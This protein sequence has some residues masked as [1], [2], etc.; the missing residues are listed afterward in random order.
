M[1][2]TRWASML[3]GL[4]AVALG[5]H[6]VASPAFAQNS[7]LR[8]GLFGRAPE[9]KA[10]MPAVSRFVSE[11]GESFVLDRSGQKALLRFEG[12]PEVWVLTPQYAPR[13]DILYKNDQGAT[14][15]RATRVGGVIVFTADRPGGAAAAP[16]GATAPLRLNAIG[17]QQLL[18]VLA[19]ASTRASHAAQRLIPFEAD[20]TPDTS[21]L[22]ADAAMVTS[23]AVMR[24]SRRGDGK[25]L[26]G[27]VTRVSIGAGDKPQVILDGG[28]LKVIVAPSMGLS[29]RPS[30]D[31]IAFVLGAR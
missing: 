25:K 28:A 31:R 11:T 1:V 18:R 29:G 13:G 3:A 22:V 20:A 4:M 15:L 21:A 16:A 24:L 9:R 17:P 8:E 30:S 19:I 10:K 23:E 5:I 14:M 6:A 2:A 26:L 27:R 12:S 7:P